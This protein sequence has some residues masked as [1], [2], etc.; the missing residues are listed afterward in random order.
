MGVQEL[1][2]RAYDRY[3]HGRTVPYGRQRVFVRNF[4]MTRTV[5]QS[6]SLFFMHNSVKDGAVYVVPNYIVSGGL[7]KYQSLM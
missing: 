4:I 2:K 3:G 5:Y 6:P 1:H 7:M